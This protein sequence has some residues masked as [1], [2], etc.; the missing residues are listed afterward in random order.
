MREYRSTIA[1]VYL[2]RGTE[3]D[4][5]DSF[6]RFIASYQEFPS[7]RGHAL[8]VVY[9]GFRS[10]TE[11]ERAIRLFSALDARAIKTGDDRFDIGAYLIAAKEI[12]EDQVCFLNTNSELLASAWLQK[13]ALH[14][15]RPEV[16]LVG[17]TGSFESLSTL[18]PRFQPFPNVHIRSNG[19]MVGRELFGDL[20]GGT[21]IHNK[22]DAYFVESGPASLTQRVLARGLNVM[23]VGRNGR[24]YPPRW[25]PSSDTLRQ[26]SQ[27]NLLIGDNLT[28]AYMAMTWDAKR[29]NVERTWGHYLDPFNALAS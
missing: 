24:G 5:L 25:W 29:A 8:Y 15:D 4:W 23:V 9:K 11:M 27:A 17:A 18:G 22:L 16:G 7:G 21:I 1:V 13:L 10:A 28:R 26:G 6:R 12:T 3:D 19:F 20:L 2:A 14:L